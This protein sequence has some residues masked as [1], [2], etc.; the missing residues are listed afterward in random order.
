MP[1][2]TPTQFDPTQLKSS[3]NRLMQFRPRR[4]YL[5]H[6]SE[7]TDCARLANDMIDAIDVFV[8]IAR[9]AGLDNV[10]RIRAGLRELAH[11]SLRAHGCTMTAA[12][13]DEILG[14]DFD[15]NAAGLDAWLRREAG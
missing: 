12:Q 4:L 15:L 11:T 8:R 3:I 2:T 7:V 1:T 13:I 14:K 9:G 5:T 10:A 6:Y